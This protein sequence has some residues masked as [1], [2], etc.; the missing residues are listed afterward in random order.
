V[1]LDDDPATVTLLSHQLGLISRAQ[2]LGRGWRADQVDGAVG[3][4]RLERVHRAVYRVPGGGRPGGQAAMA[5][6]LRI[7][8]GARITGEG[9]LAHHHV[10]GI[11]PHAVGT[12]LV[13]P[14][15]RPRSVPVVWRRDRAPA[16]DLARLGPIPGTTVDRALV[17]LAG[18]RPARRWLAAFDASRWRRLAS[19]A[20]VLEVAAR[21][22][23]SHPGT[24]AV[25]RLAD[26]GELAQESHGERDLAAAL[27]AIGIHEPEVRWQQQVSDRHRVDAFLPEHRLVL[28]Y[29]GRD[30]HTDG[31]DRARDRERD[32][33]LH[34]LGLEVLHLR[35]EDLRDHRHLRA[36]LARA[37]AR[38]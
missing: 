38:C 14:P 4:G 19:T 29:D 11:D 26:A 35:A 28:E 3:A 9:V 13:R 32:R 25:E 31:R 5:A 30:V 16:H 12:V 6:V 2:L 8:E 33:E 27:R 36:R 22:G 1:H 18:D 34:A 10:A 15:R 7:G 37:I 24:R 23:R 20:G 21:I 17:E